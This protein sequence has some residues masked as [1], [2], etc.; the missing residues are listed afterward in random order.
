M[1]SGMDV[2]VAGKRCNKS[3]RKEKMP[4][5]LTKQAAYGRKAHRH[6]S[7]QRQH[8]SGPITSTLAA[9]HLQQCRQHA[10]C[11]ASR[12]HQHGHEEPTTHDCR[13]RATRRPPS[14][15][16]NAV[17]PEAQQLH[18][19][20]ARLCRHLGEVLISSH[21]HH[22]PPVTTITT[23]IPSATTHQTRGQIRAAITATL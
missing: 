13:A 19:T 8:D 18:V 6:L 17:Q 7:Q 4:I 2:V 15:P 5:K 16:H 22:V 14:P 23:H 9:T 21:M 12:R 1:C 20:R 11:P 3:T 10:G